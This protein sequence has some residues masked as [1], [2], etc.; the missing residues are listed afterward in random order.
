MS[1]PAHEWPPQ[2]DRWPRESQVAYLTF[3]HRRPELVKIIGELAGI[4]SIAERDID[5][6][7]ARLDK[8]ELAAVALELGIY[9]RDLDQAADPWI[10][11]GNQ[12]VSEE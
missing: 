2:F 11:S 10:L 7:N 3:M 4:D 8:D 5:P 1:E 6:N 12:G 9:R